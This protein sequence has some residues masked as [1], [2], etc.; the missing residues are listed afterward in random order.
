VPLPPSERRSSA[1]A[2]IA[3]GA[4][5]RRKPTCGDESRDRPIPVKVED[6]AVSRRDPIFRSQV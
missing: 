4:D 1:F 2:A 3:R 5:P 6:A